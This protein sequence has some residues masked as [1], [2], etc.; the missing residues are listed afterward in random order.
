MKFLIDFNNSTAQADIDAYFITNNCTVINCFDKL[1]QVYHAN[2][3]TTP[4]TTNIVESIINDDS[5]TIQLLSV[6]P[7]S[8]PVASSDE[9]LTLADTKQWWKVYSVSDIDFNAP[10]SVVPRFGANTNVYVVDS[11]IEATHP[12]F[13][14]R[15]V[16]LVYSFTGEFTDT[17]GH[18]TALS[19][20][21]IGNTCGLTDASLKVVKIFDKVIPTRQSDL[22]YAF[23]AILTDALLSNKFSVVNLSWSIPKNLYIES[24]IQCL[25]DAGMV[26]VVAAGNSGQP[27]SD[28]TPAS[29]PGVLA[30][31]SYGENFVPSNF[32][33][34]TSITSVT[35]DAVN[36][37]SLSAWAPGEHIWCAGLNGSYGNVSGTSIAAAIYSGGVCYNKSQYLMD[38]N[39]LM[40][41]F[42]DHTGVA[43]L[44]K[45]VA[46]DRNGILELSDPKYAQ[47]ANIIITYFVAERSSKLHRVLP[48]KLV[49]RTGS[50]ASTRMFTLGL[51][52]AYEILTPLPSAA[53]LVRNFI[54][55]SPTT[56][57][58]DPSG[59][60]TY[61]FNYR[62]YPSDSTPP[63][64]TS[65][66]F[67]NITPTFDSN[68]LPTSS[69]LLEITA[70]FECVGLPSPCAGGTCPD[71]PPITCTSTVSS[72]NCWCGVP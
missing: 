69:P 34:Y 14:D 25:I 31:G 70:L 35:Q 55:F 63:F 7:V 42:F 12:E 50:S 59:V 65:I 58:I 3:T 51:T 26:V 11:G 43:N 21:I 62:I 28:V 24:K 47:S 19:S 33:N 53:V 6:V 15:S 48:G 40:S 27:I 36:H 32:S 60:D 71:D 61:V 22:L 1:G 37:G 41:V 68:T 44:G 66:T 2:C 46:V 5:T 10:T 16:S 45:I 67:V 54:I 18:G 64:E 39:A 17:T 72:K 8:L 38:N 57:P 4:P 52:S 20:S 23:D 9:T 13:I 29:T 49:A 30:I 56:L